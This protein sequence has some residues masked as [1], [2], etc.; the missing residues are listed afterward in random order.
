[1]RRTYTPLTPGCNLRFVGETNT[2]EPYQVLWKVLNRG[3]VAI[4]RDSVRGQ[5]FSTNYILNEEKSDFKGDHYVECYIV[6][7]GVCVAKRRIDVPIRIS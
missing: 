1:M 5:I 6:K 3:P 7:D 2:P 4:E